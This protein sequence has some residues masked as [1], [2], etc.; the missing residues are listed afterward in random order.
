[1]TLV[2]QLAAPPLHVLVDA[3]Q[4]EQVIVNL[5]VNG[6][7][8]MPGGGRLVIETEVVTLDEQALE[9][10]PSMSPGRYA[11]LAVTD[12]GHGM[13]ADVQVR[14]FEPFFTTKEPGK[15]TGLGLA[16]SYGIVKQSGGWIWMYSE[17]GHGSVFKIFLPLAVDFIS[18]P[19][20]PDALASA[21]RTAIDRP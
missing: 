6:R 18:Q 5:A 19:L 21:A 3:G 1:V 17:V 7:D 14:I 15:G 11:Q 16:M 13:D 2:T 10:R 12:T 20:P 8:A 4:I 9:A